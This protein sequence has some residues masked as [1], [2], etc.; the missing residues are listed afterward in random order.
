MEKVEIISWTVLE[1]G[2]WGSKREDRQG[3][4]LDFEI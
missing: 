4:S 1:L 3:S 2:K